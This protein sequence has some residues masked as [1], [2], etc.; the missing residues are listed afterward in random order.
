[1]EFATFVMRIASLV[2]CIK[3][4]LQMEYQTIA[5][6]VY[7]QSIFLDQPVWRIAQQDII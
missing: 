4:D 5:S 7:H 1:M 6:L 2:W 3:L